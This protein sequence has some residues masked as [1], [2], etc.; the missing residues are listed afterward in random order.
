MK[1]VEEHTVRIILILA[2]L[3]LWGQFLY[4]QEDAILQT[5]RIE[6]ASDEELIEMAAIRGIA[7]SDPASLRQ[8]LYDY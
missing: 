7:E 8:A 3:V 5:L 6:Q 4:A 2:L 1:K